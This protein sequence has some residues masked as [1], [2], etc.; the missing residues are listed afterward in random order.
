MTTRIVGIVNEL[1]QMRWPSVVVGR[2]RRWRRC[3]RRRVYHFGR[4]IDISS[5]AAA[6]GVAVV[7][8]V[9]VGTPPPSTT[10]GYSY[11]ARQRRHNDN[12]QRVRPYFVHFLRTITLFNF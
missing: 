3:R 9:V 4:R 5:P 7:V 11:L 10:K 1:L 2:S 6:T 8:T 12:G